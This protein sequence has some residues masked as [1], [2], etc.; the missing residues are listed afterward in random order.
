[1]YHVA[2]K[3]ADG[4]SVVKHT[5]SLDYANKVRRKWEKAGY[6]AFVEEDQQWDDEYD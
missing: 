3:F 5:R 4:W 1:M 2:V 6:E